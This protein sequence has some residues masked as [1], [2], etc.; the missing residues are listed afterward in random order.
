MSACFNLF[1]ALAVIK[2]YY[3][4]LLKSFPKDHMTS[5]GRYLKIRKLSDET[6]D[7]II[8]AG[9]SDQA[10]RRLFGYMTCVISP[11]HEDSLFTFCSNLEDVIGNPE[12]Q[13]VIEQLRN[14][15]FCV[16]S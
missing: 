13:S 1:I 4:V 15:Q 7:F 3:V 14:G 9:N 11:E 8:S 5:L 6:V 2:K 16:L 12:I 10:N